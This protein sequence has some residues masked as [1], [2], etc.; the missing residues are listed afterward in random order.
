[1][2]IKEKVKRQMQV[3]RNARQNRQNKLDKIKEIVEDV[4]LRKKAQK[5]LLISTKCWAC[6]SELL[7]TVDGK[8]LYCPNEM[9]L[10]DEQVD[11]IDEEE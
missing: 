6:G 8:H 3:I 1:M 9:C 2:N 5:E 4:K 10:M 7:K 11:I